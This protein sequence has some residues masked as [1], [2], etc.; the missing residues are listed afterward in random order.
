MFSILKTGLLGLS[1]GTGL[2]LMGSTVASAA[3]HPTTDPS[4]QA[5][6]CTMCQVTWVK[7]PDRNQKGHI[8]GYKW[9]KK[10]TCPDCLDAFTNFINTGK[11]ERTCKACG[12]EMVMC[13]AHEAHTK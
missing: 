11:F 2:L 13:D 9:G 12:G 1:I 4:P 5:M 7:V 8:I 10:D 6:T 3:E